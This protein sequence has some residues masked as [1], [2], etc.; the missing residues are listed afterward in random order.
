M[1][2]SRVCSAIKNGIGGITRNGKPANSAE[3]RSVKAGGNG[4]KEHVVASSVINWR[5]AGLCRRNSVPH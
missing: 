2:L 5:V 1:L 3:D 4:E